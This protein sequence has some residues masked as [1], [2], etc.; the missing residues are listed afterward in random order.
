MNE[1]PPSLVLSR[2]GIGV[3]VVSDPLTHSWLKARTSPYFSHSSG[4]DNGSMWQVIAGSEFAPAGRWKTYYRQSANGERCKYLVDLQAKLIV[5]DLPLGPWRQLFTLR[6]I[7][8]IFRWELFLQGAVFLHASCV[9]IKG[10]GIAL[11]GQSRGGKTTALLNLLERGHADYVTE[12]DLTVVAQTN[13]TF[14]AL[15]WP[16]CVRVRRSM[17]PQF[18]DLQINP[19]KFT[20]PANGLEDA[21]NP[22][23][24]LLR[25]FPEELSS[26]YGCNIVPEVTLDIGAWCH[27]NKT[28]ETLPMSLEETSEGLRLS[29]DILPERKAGARPGLMDRNKP[30]WA[31]LVFDPF[32]LEA[33]GVP[34]LKG[35]ELTLHQIAENMRGFKVFH[36]GETSKFNCMF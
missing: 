3:Q 31:S 14:R 11:L 12:D 6:I 25:V 15:G 26:M 5:V 20:H 28:Q 32:L 10:R 13:G 16:G 8:N 21:M 34:D 27:W 1:A 17:I 2:M 9:S 18:A 33:Y 29:W 24:G 23:V 19:H 30:E 36:C 35:H 4:S 7:R 22:D